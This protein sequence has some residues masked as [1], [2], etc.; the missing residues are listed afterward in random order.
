M[1]KIGVGSGPGIETI[2]GNEHTLA[3][4]LTVAPSGAATNQTNA[5]PLPEFQRAYTM[6]LG[7]RPAGSTSGTTSFTWTPVTGPKIAETARPAPPSP[8]GA[9]VP[10]SIP[11]TM[12][13]GHTHRSAGV[14]Q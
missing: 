11:E 5:C 7:P 3:G 4:M 1:V 9:G 10:L 8:S 13:A 2:C 6:S 14:P 12:A